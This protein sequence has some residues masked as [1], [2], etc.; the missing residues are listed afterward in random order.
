MVG[1]VNYYGTK[2]ASKTKKMPYISKNLYIG[3]G[4]TPISHKKFLELKKW[5]KEHTLIQKGYTEEPVKKYFGKDYG[6]FLSQ[7]FWSHIATVRP[8]F[9]LS[10]VIADKIAKEIFKFPQ[11]DNVYYS[12]ERDRDD[13][14]Y[15]M[16]LLFNSSRKY[17]HRR[18]VASMIGYPKN[19]KFVNYLA[20]VDNDSKAIGGYINKY[21]GSHKQLCHGF[22]KK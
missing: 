6:K 22:H 14:F 20:H 15:H 8:N 18:D 17:L 13:K 2:V 7:Y 21:M 11:V 4:P 3:E 1:E 16:H 5:H 9:R 19:T 10:E 12:V